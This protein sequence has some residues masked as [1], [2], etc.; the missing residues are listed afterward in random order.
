MNPNSL[1]TE[2]LQV[3][4]YDFDPDGTDPVDV[5]WLAAKNFDRF[6][7][8]FFRTIGTGNV[9]TMR[10]L[11]NTALDGSGTD[12]TVKTKTLTSVQ[13]NALG[14]YSFVEVSAGE[15]AAAAK[16]AGVDVVAVALQLEF[17]TGTDEGVVTYVFGGAKYPQAAL[18]ADNIA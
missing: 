8:A 12:V 15:I 4:Q 1:L 5:A 16:A 13:P 18:T 2:N 6:L 9:D 14:D 10:V 17:A 11:A 7:F 3:K